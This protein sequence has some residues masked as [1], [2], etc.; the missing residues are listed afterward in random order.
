ML[1]RLLLCLALVCLSNCSETRPPPP[2][3]IVLITADDLNWD[4]VGCNGCSIPDITPHIDR[5]AEEGIL[6]REAHATVS[7]C[8]PVRA[9]MHTG[10]YPARSGARGFQP[11]GE[12]IPTMNEALDEAGYLISMLAKTP[13]YK[14]IEK[15]RVDYLVHATELDVGRNPEKF[16]EH[17]RRFLAMAAEQDKP[18]FHHVNCQDPHRPFLWSGEVSNE[19]TFPEVRRVIRPEEVE[20]PPFLADLP[21]VRQE[22]A[23][24]FTCVH[25]LDECVG[26]VMSELKAAGR[27]RDTLVVF[28]GGDHGMAFPFAKANV[29]A[30]SS[31]ATLILRWP[32]V[33]PAGQVDESHLVASIDMAPTLLE[34]AGLPRLEGV[35]GRSFLSIA[36]GGRQEG[37]GQVITVFHE[38]HG[39]RQLEMRCVR[40]REDAYIWNAWSDGEQ[41]YRAE[42]MAGQTWKAMLEASETDPAMKARCEFYLKRVPQEYYRL[43]GDPAERRNLI[44]DAH[45]AAEIAAKREQ[46]ERWLVGMNDPLLEQFRELAGD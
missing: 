40:S 12:D 10:L 19:G 38:T 25:R 3:N 16:A 6:F 5:L 42:N 30:N 23:D 7:V 46:L 28:F 11:I 1:P 27:D 45:Y 2:L 39:E 26:A 31:R 35:D 41:T 33:I 8:L 21:E 32:D 43:D 36:R 24:Y 44:D 13:H 9:T 29:Y 34:A 17:T 20:V 22:I 4:S 37:R 15:Y 14:P 18:F